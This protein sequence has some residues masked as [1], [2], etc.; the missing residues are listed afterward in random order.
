MSITIDEAGLQ[1]FL[2]Q[3]VSDMGAAVNSGH[4]RN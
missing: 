1:A 4:A 3:A 2:G